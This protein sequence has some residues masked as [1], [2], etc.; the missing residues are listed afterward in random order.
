MWQQ[1]S[2]RSQVFR[3]PKPC[4]STQNG[5]FGTHLVPIDG[6]CFWDLLRYPFIDLLGNTV[7]VRLLPNAQP[8]ETAVEPG[9]GVEEEP[10]PEKHPSG[11]ILLY[12]LESIEKPHTQIMTSGTIFS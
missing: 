12:S 4:D 6:R 9:D 7:A 5:P 11:L 1:I 8:P 2:L 3:L 10:R